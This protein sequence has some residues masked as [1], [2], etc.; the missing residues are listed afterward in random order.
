VKELTDDERHNVKEYCSR[1]NLRSL[2]KKTMDPNAREQEV[3]IE[4]LEHV[5]SN[6]VE[7]KQSDITLCCKI[8]DCRVFTALCRESSGNGSRV[9]YLF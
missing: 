5:L 8:G 3:A 1:N 9:S 4:L 6:G 7:P 2:I